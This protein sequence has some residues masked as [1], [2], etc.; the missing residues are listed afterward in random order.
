MTEQ[1]I[2]AM[3]EELG[4]NGAL[5]MGAEWFVSHLWHSPDKPRDE[6]KPFLVVT[7]G[8]SICSVFPDQ[9]EQWQ[10]DVQMI[11][12][13]AWCYLEDILPNYINIK[14]LN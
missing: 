8:G 2:K 6:K 12:I 14:K 7:K 1:T 13:C 5:L 4:S 3:C 9:C 11:N 10:V